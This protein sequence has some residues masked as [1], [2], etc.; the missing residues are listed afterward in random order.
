MSQEQIQVPKGWKMEKLSNLINIH[1]GFAFKS[2]DYSKNGIF[3]LR[4]LNISSDGKINRN[5][6]VCIPNSMLSKFPKY[7][8][9][10]KNFE[11]KSNFLSF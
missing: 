8:L 2:Q 1:S 11:H 9:K 6:P 10:K 3:V 4:T 7:V 5:N